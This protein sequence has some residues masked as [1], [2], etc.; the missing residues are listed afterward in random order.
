M[1]TVPHRKLII[2]PVRLGSHT[3]AIVLPAWWMKLNCN[4]ESVEMVLSL[5]SI[6]V[7]PV[8]KE[9][10]SEPSPANTVREG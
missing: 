3:R 10:A 1:S 7:R 9:K 4:P 2:Q 6:E 8:G 5:D